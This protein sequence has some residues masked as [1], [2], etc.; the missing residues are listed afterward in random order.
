MAHQQRD[1]RGRRSTQLSD[2][3][4]ALTDLSRRTIGCAIEVHK[5]LGPGYPLDIYLNALKIE[6]KHEKIDAEYDKKYE[7]DY[8]DD[9]L[10]SVTADLVIGDRFIVALLAEDR[11]VTGQERTAL[12]AVLR[13]ADLELGLIINFGQ[14]RLK[15]GLVRVLNPDALRNDDDDEEY[16]DDD[17][18]SDASE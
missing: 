18:D 11:D 6:F 1:S 13:A 14:R 16:E 4:P 17:E 2:L 5:E 12:R 15:D 9:I 10:G 8:D 7:L 3:D